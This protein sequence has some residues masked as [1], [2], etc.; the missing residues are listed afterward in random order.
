MVLHFRKFMTFRG[1]VCSSHRRRRCAGKTIVRP[2]SRKSSQNSTE[3]RWFYSFTIFIVLRV[4]FASFE[5]VC[6]CVCTAHRQF[7]KCN[8]EVGIKCWQLFQWKRL[9]L[10]VAFFFLVFSLLFS[11]YLRRLEHVQTM[12]PEQFFH[13]LSF[14]R[15]LA[16]SFIVV[17]VKVQQE[18][19]CK[20][21]KNAIW[22]VI[23]YSR[24]WST[25]NRSH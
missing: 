20:R 15:L 16:S 13:L 18:K 25:W 1:D 19:R 14:A 5:S 11:T 23:N 17:V 9:K 3:L 8:L 4:H 6:V 22:F 2:F 21:M 7:E 10:L 12:H 24:M